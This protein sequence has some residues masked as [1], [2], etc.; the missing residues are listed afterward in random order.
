MGG[1]ID[2]GSEGDG[3]GVSN[4]EKVRTTVNEQEYILKIQTHKYKK[5]Y[6]GKGYEVK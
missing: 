3:V 4:G 6:N 1:R 5:S 2:C